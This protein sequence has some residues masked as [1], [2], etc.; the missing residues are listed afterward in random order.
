MRDAG[1]V[2]PGPIGTEAVWE[3]LFSSAALLYV[4]AGIAVFFCDPHA[5]WQRGTNE[6]T[7]GLLRQYFPKGFDFSTITEPPLRHILFRTAAKSLLSA[8]G[9]PVG[10]PPAA[11][12]PVPV[13]G[14]RSTAWPPD[15]RRYDQTSIDARPTS[16]CPR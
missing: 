14:R 4:D 15:H 3:P 12:H 8:T 13:S 6:N 11:R 10:V 2:S 1:V 7:N 5:P 9:L 16:P